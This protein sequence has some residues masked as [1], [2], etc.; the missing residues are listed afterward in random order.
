MIWLTIQ[1]KRQIGFQFIEIVFPP[2]V[3]RGHQTSRFF[4]VPWLPF[5]YCFSFQ[6]PFV[7]S[8]KE[9]CHVF[10][11]FFFNSGWSVINFLPFCI[12]PYDLWYIHIHTSIYFA[13]VSVL[14]HLYLPLWQRKT[15]S[16]IFLKSIHL[17]L[18]Y[19]HMIFLYSKTG[20]IW[21]NGYFLMTFRKLR[22]W[23][24]F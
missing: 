19:I 17:N 16:T 1:R 3:G 23:L 20:D 13:S 11:T 22:T 24:S 15:H 6:C 12:I 4:C 5:Y 7:F 2:R 8:F 21:R 9:L 18:L 14:L 10:I